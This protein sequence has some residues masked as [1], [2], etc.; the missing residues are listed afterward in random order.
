MRTALADGRALGLLPGD[1]EHD[2]APRIV[3][4]TLRAD[5][6]PAAVAIGAD[7]GWRAALSVAMADLPS[8]EPSGKVLSLKLDVVVDVGEALSLTRDGSLALE[9]RDQGL[10]FDAR[11]AVAFLP[12]ELAAGSLMRDDR[13]VR[14]GGMRRYLARQP[15]R[16]RRAS[17][18][19]A[20]PQRV[21]P[22]RTASVFVDARGATT[23]VNGHRPVPVASPPLLAES[24]RL[25]GGYLAGAVAPSG[26][27]RYAYHVRSG[28]EP[29]EYNIL[30]HAGTAYAMLDLWRETQRPELL[31]AA[32]RALGYLSRFLVSP[33]PGSLQLAVAHEGAVKLGGVALAA[34]AFIEHER[35]TGKETYRETAVK[36]CAF[37][38]GAM[39]DGGRFSHRWS[40]PSWELESFESL[41]YSGEALLAL[42]RMYSIDGD[43]AWLDAAE[44][45]ARHQISTYGQAA[46]K[47]LPAD[48]WV[49]CALSELHVHR[50]QDEYVGY[51]SKVA[52]RLSAEQID[53]HRVSDFVGGFG[54]R[55]PSS[56]QAAAR[57]EGLLAAHAI[58]SRAG[59]KAA[60]APIL[61]AIE[62]SV[63]FQLGTQ[64]W[65]ECVLYLRRP[66]EALGG[67]PR[68][69]TSDEVRIDYVQHNVTGIL[70]YLRLLRDGMAEVLPQA[71]NAAD[72]SFENW[73][74]NQHQQ[75]AW[76]PASDQSPLDAATLAASLAVAEEHLIASQRP[77]GLFIYAYDFVARQSSPDDNL[78]R[79]AGATWGL[80]LMYARDR[81]EETRAPLLRAVDA[82]ESLERGAGQGRPTGMIAYPGDRW[83]ATGAVALVGLALVEYL[84]VEAEPSEDDAQRRSRVAQLDRCIS[85][86]LEAQRD[87]G[88]FVDRRAVADGHAATRPSPYS[89]G[90][91]LL[92]LVKAASYLG[93]DDLRPAI[94]RSALRLAERYTRE[95]WQ[96]DADSAATKGF[97]QWGCMAF[98]EYAL[99]GW[100]NSEALSQTVL[101]LASWMIRVHHTLDRPRNTAYAHEGLIQA[102][103]LAKLRREEGAMAE[104]A[105]VVSQGLGKLVTWQVGGPLAERNAFLQRHPSDD[106]L[107][108]GGIMN[109]RADPELRIDVTQHQAHA[110]M[111]ALAHL[112]ETP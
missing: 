52:G 88:S 91:A 47:D 69:F 111:L 108:V 30:R 25:A 45:G 82:F 5:G 40:Y 37:L 32:E 55:D 3:F 98:T 62:R 92:C 65:P 19:N 70:R 105:S 94:E 95:A 21:R 102:Y 83:C 41:Y 112:C 39:D 1:L 85:Y 18:P 106:P 86:L 63:A 20:W 93:R 96:N 10:A 35:A 48:H 81:K 58:A 76:E 84:H 8:R 61:A 12:E 87:D 33:E 90:E 101:V 64:L 78:V 67:F 28:R 110:L 79:Q 74:A 13:R 7:R 17:L 53:Q 68:S 97:F 31:S 4:L 36:L 107:A 9:A 11:H 22:F 44:R 75:L 43:E 80:A 29:D 66:E 59:E 2:E 104:L 109:H 24:L 6:G 100:E 54:R 26:E 16:M 34:L 27:F 15:E 77:D 14:Q 49:T 99:A 60:A 57:T 42:V 51:A 23:L 38:V 71:G 46:T 50:P 72:E 89:D 73:I 56:A 103:R